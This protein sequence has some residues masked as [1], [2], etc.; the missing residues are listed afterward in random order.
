MVGYDRYSAQYLIQ[1]LNT[2]GFLTDDVYQGENLT[3]VINEFEG[4]LKDGVIKIGDNSLL[5]MHLLDSALRINS[6]TNRKRLVKLNQY[7]HIDGTAALLDAFCVK[8]KWHDTYGEQLKN[9][10]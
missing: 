8:Q 3:P 1:D 6:E 2:Y 4:K 10:G 9:E 7:A 5:K